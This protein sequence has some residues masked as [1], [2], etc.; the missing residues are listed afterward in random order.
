[1]MRGRF[2]PQAIRMTDYLPHEHRFIKRCQVAATRFFHPDGTPR[3]LAAA[4]A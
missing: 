3:Q 4:T 2:G 1:M